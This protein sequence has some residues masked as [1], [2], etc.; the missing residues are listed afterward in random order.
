MLAIL[1]LTGGWAGLPDGFL[2]GDAF[3][4]FL[5]PVFSF[6][7]PA[8]A[9]AVP[10][11]QVMALSMKLSA[12]ALAAALIGIA[13]AWILYIHHP[14][15][16]A[17]AAARMRALRQILVRKYYVDELYD[18]VISRPLFWG[19]QTVLDRGVD[20]MVIDRIADGTGLT[21]QSGGEGLRRLA[22]GNVRHYALVYMLGA[23]A[24]AAYYVYLVMR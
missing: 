3:G 21:V 11:T 19:S 20:A 16:P 12:V 2:W 6:T 15:T 17:R 5:A 1:S 22:T 7:A 13:L 23:L 10:A 24:V 4:R 8:A 18:L 9:L 14:G